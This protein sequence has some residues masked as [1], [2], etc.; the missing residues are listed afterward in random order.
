MQQAPARSVTRAGLPA[1][2][3]ALATSFAGAAVAQQVPPKLASRIMSPGK[4]PVVERT[5]NGEAF[6]GNAV[7]SETPYILWPAGRREAPPF[8]HDRRAV[9]EWLTRAG[10][11]LGHREFR[12]SYVATESWR[13]DEVWVYRLEHR[14]IPLHGARVMVQW[15][16]D[17]LV[18]LV[19]EVD[20]PLLSVEEP[21]LDTPRDGSVVYSAVREPAGYRA[22]LQP[23][24]VE[25]RGG[26]V[27]TTI[28]SRTSVVASPA[29]A[30][31]PVT[32][33]MF[34]EWTVPAGSS[35]PDQIDVD[36]NGKVW[37]SQPSDN[38]L[39][40][41]DPLTQAF[42][43]FPTTGG[44]G[45]DGMTVDAN[46]I[47]WTGLYYS[48]HLGRLDPTTGVHTTF[49]MPY[50]TSSPAIPKETSLGTLWVTDHAQNRISEFDLAAQ[51]WAGSY[52]IPTA[53]SWVVEGDEDPVT[54]TVYFTCYA[55]NKLAYKPLGLP[56]QETNTVPGGP[57]FP[58]VSQ[59]KV[60]YS[61]W[62]SAALGVYDPV[63]GTHTSYA[64]PVGG[65]VG[66]P[67]GATSGGR[68]VVGTR[69]VGYLFVFDPVTQRF[70]SYKIP[71]AFSGLKDGL[72]VGPDDNVWF[73]E[74]GGN[75]LAR[76]LL[77]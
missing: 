44:S 75:K 10:R 2:V 31:A 17:R 29:P 45:P 34:R 35:F 15:S 43:Q 39:T 38:F 40:R 57:S 23:V 18:G 51:A 33:Q 20:L 61:L 65:E 21:T 37:F 48:G 74:S 49:T 50:S 64:F 73:T 77:H 14:G 7:F 60:Y 62:T 66:G 11:E 26:L 25:R 76:L 53:S 71:S 8:A 72:V 41:F 59:G 6:R 3:L 46:D 4:V 63:A 1:I 32:P 47:V 22:V 19:N 42:Q 54:K 16:D 70:A 69:N 67:I 36:G 5:L 13:G 28:G 12:S 27:I 24:H 58:V 30:P 9:G 56:V 68:I 55:V 52:V